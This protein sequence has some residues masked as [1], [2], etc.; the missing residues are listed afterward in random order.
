MADEVSVPKVVNA[1]PE[2]TKE[3]VKDPTPEPE[4]K[5]ELD[6]LKETVVKLTE[7]NK[8]LMSETISK[9][10]RSFTS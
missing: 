9:R 10:G 1:N 6:E 5:S 8:S 3:V 2:P 4:K 7:D